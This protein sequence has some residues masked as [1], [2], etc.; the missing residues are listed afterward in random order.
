MKNNDKKIISEVMPKLDPHV[1][2]PPIYTRF[3][4]DTLLRYPQAFS[5]SIIATL[6]ENKLPEQ[7]F[8]VS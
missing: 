5:R 3:L 8:F 7:E 2:F 1:T 4:S 6:R